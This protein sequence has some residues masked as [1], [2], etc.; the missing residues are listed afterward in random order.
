MSPLTFG[1]PDIF[2]MKSKHDLRGLIKALAHKDPQICSAAVKAL[3]DLEEPEGVMA[4]ARLGN[5]AIEPLMTMGFFGGRRME[6][7]ANALASIG[8]GVPALMA[9]KLRS[10]VFEER[11]LAAKVLERIQWEPAGDEDRVWYL[12]GKSDWESVKRLGAKSA[13]VLIEILQKWRHRHGKTV[14]VDWERA[15]KTLAEIEWQPQSDTERAWQYAA[16]HDWD[17]CSALGSVAVPPLIA[18][19]K[20]Y[21]YPAIEGLWTTEVPEYYTDLHNKIAATLRHMTGQDFG[22]DGIQWQQWW[23]RQQ[24]SA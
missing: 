3:L 19:L 5:K 1:K 11:R 21:G 8:H 6:L 4:V 22:I 20:A 15:E 13:S 16:R 2:E 17:G 23:E 18:F 14:F 12:I 9:A 10:P 7:A 24:Q